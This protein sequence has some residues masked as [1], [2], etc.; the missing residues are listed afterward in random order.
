MI[1]LH[2]V[3]DEHRAFQCP[4]C[5]DVHMVRVEGPNAW[6]WNGDEVLPTIRP[7]ILATRPGMP[8]YRCHSYVT[9]G[10]ISFLSDCSHE[11]TGQT[12][13]IPEWQ[14]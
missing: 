7:S 9:D 4:A 8:E 10:Q 5:N 6:E 14:T 1:K 12:M 3:N 11:H 2:Q 13:E